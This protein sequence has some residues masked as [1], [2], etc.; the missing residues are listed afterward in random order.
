MNAMNPPSFPSLR[1]TAA[2]PAN[3][4]KPAF[5][6]AALGAVCLLS[7][8]L[9]AQDTPPSPDPT[10]DTFTPAEYSIDRYQRLRGKSPFEFELAKPLVEA[11]ADPFADLVLAGYAGSA[12]RPT[13][14]VV[15]TKTQERL[16]ILPEGSSKK[17]SVSTVAGISP[18]PP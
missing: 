1:P 11:P 2:P 13:V 7:V 12:S 6:M 17:A 14:Y 4:G 3:P 18:R 15:N 9:H 10:T 16:T 5:P 8:S